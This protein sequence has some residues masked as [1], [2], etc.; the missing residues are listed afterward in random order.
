M[1]ENE[2]QEVEVFD[3]V[4]DEE[5]GSFDESWADDDEEVTDTGDE[6]SAKDCGS[7]TCAVAPADGSADDRDSDC[8]GL[9]AGC[10][11]L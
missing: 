7:D 10:C 8:L 1:E 11:C 2:A 9:A 6:G 5:L 4:S 3:E